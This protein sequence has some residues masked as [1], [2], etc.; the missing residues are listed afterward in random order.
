MFCA[1]V[2]VLSCT[3]GVGYRF[4]VLLS[5]LVFSGTKGVGSRFHF[6]L[7]GLIFGGTDGV[8]SRFHVL[9]ARTN[10]RLYRGRRVPF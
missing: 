7:T 3:E 8:E 5:G 6:L 4:H 10:F 9:R 1:L 2:L